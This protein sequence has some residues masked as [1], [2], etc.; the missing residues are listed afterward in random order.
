M[1]QAGEREDQ[2]HRHAQRQMKLEHQPHVDQQGQGAR[3]ER[4]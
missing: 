3:V 4:D 2:E 1:N